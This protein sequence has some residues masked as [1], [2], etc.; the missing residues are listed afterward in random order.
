MTQFHGGSRGKVTIGGTELPIVGWEGDFVCERIDV[1][2][3]TGNGWA[4]FIPGVLQGSVKFTLLWDA[5]DI[6][7]GTLGLIEGATLACALF[8]GSTSENFA[9]NVF[10]ERCRYVSQVRARPLTV[11]VEGYFTGAWTRPAD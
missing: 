6:P 7:S 10:L 8:C 1:T 9:G 4:E 2:H 11:E 5:D 3:A